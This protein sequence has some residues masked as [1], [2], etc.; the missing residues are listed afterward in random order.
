MDAP[1]PGDATATDPAAQSER[2]APAGLESGSSMDT[3]APG[4]GTATDPAAPSAAATPD[5]DAGTGDGDVERP[6]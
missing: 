6:G 5:P 1:A 2:V 3:P 4:E